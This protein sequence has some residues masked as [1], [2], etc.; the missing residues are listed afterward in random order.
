MPM[1]ASDII[2]HIKEALPDADVELQDLAGDND[3]FAVKVISASFTGKSRVI[4]HKL[5]MDALKG[6]VGGDL[7]ALSIRTEAR[8]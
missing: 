4:Q 1:E 7:H 2:G 8:P 3:H 5:V 6:K